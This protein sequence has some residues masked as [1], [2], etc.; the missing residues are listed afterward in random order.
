M[1][2]KFSFL[3]FKFFNFYKELY[4]Y[5]LHKMKLQKTYLSKPPSPSPF[6]YFPPSL[7]SPA[8]DPSLLPP[9]IACFVQP[10]SRIWGCFCGGWWMCGFTYGIGADGE[11]I[12]LNAWMTRRVI[13]FRICGVSR[14]KRRWRRRNLREN[15]LMRLESP[16]PLRPLPPLVAVIPWSFGRLSLY[17]LVFRPPVLVI[18]WPFGRLC[19]LS[20]P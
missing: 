10:G 6:P 14:V 8:W 4:Y 7:S 2:W 17:P 20:L 11:V 3:S 19:M 16:S 9:Q 1:N 13:L 5:P 18:T 12:W 15:N